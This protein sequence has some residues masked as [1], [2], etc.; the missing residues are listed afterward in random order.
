MHSYKVQTKDHIT[1]HVQKWND[2]KTSKGTLFIIH[3]LGEHQWR[4][5]HLAKFYIDNGFQVYSYDQRGHGESKGKRG[6]SPSLDYSLDDL[7]RVLKT[8]P[9]Y[10]LFLYGHSFGGSVLLNFLL[11]KQPKFLKGAIVSA[12]W[13]KLIKKP[14]V[15]ELGLSK[16]MNGIY[17]GLT[18]NNKIDPN[19]FSYDPKVFTNYKEDLL[20]HNR[21]S[22]RLFCEFYSAGKW[23]LENAS[24]LSV[25][26]F[27]IHG[28]EDPII[29]KSGSQY[30]AQSNK[31]KVT[32]K[33]FSNTKHEPHNDLTKETVFADTL[34]WLEEMLNIKK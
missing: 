2:I 22:V 30:F 21:I 17:P 11:K 31:D 23:A 33:I 3:G 32:L 14:S 10:N 34:N 18:Q 1:L 7:E 13:M 26:I 12:A 16:L 25:K 6:H 5:S 27:M 19:D 29:C 9:H 15:I 4:Y 8:I 24:K 20:N 28:E